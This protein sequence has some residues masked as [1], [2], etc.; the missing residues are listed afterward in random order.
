MK[1]VSLDKL[2]ELLSALSSDGAVYAPVRRDEKDVYFSK[3]TG[4]R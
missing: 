1:R 4:G 2:N 3:W